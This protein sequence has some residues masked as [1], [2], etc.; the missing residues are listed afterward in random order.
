MQRR[1][2]LYRE[3]KETNISM[4]IDLDNRPDDFKIDSSV[5]FLDHMLTHISVHGSIGLDVQGKGDLEI[6]SHH[7]VEDSGIV[8]GQILRKVLGDMKGIFRYG[9]FTLPMDESLVDVAM[10]FSGR[11]HLHYSVPPL[12]PK[13]G[14]FDTELV[15][16][17]FYAVVRHVPMTL[18]INVRYGENSHHILEGIFKCF[19]RALSMAVAIDPKR[20]GEVPSSKGLL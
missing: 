14:D 13:V 17:F 9:H 11:S 3:S 1:A 2:E 15:Q 5:P 12:A 20:E 4:R 16:E 6:D 10:D 7:L 8:L 18:H 19:G